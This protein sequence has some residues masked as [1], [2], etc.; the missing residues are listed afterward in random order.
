ML[1]RSQIL[2]IIFVGILLLSSTTMN[3]QRASFSSF[4]ANTI[5]GQASLPSRTLWVILLITTI[6]V[7]IKMPSST[8]VNSIL[9]FSLIIYI[10]AII[11]SAIFSQYTSYSLTRGA[12]FVIYLI[13][14]PLAASLVKQLEDVGRHQRIIWWVLIFSILLSLFLILIIPDFVL[15]RNQTRFVGIFSYPNLTGRI[16]ALIILMTWM[17]PQGWI[18]LPAWLKIIVTAIM[19][20]VILDTESR[21]AIAGLLLAIGYYLWAKK[22][23][24]RIIFA[25]TVPSIA[26]ILLLFNK[27]AFEI[28]L[29][30]FGTF[31][32]STVLT[33]EEELFTITGRTGLWKAIFD[34]F[35]IGIF[36]LGYKT[37]FYASNGDILLLKKVPIFGGAHNAYIEPL[38]E[39]GIIGSVALL[40]LLVII[41]GSIFRV[42]HTNITEVKQFKIFILTTL[43]FL[44]SQ[45]F[46]IGMFDNGS[47][48]FWFI[49]YAGFLMDRINHMKPKHHIKISTESN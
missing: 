16:A 5:G 27:Q 12:S 38:V 25:F 9:F 2:L 3:L 37:L 18:N 32:H 8:I 30:L 48:F 43:L 22:Y 21:S 23:S 17:L 4:A 44:G 33:L 19:V 28:L 39:T 26:F 41:I 7:F 34:S 31:S 46:I 11:V 45:S 49:I 29:N 47:L 20:G 42:Q 36:G 1:R 15:V 14:A 35:S 6:L 40:L 24:L 10:G 13:T